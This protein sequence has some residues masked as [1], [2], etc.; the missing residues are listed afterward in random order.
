MFWTPPYSIFHQRKFYVSYVQ[1]AG[2]PMLCHAVI[3]APD[4]AYANKNWI[5]LI[6]AQGFACSPCGTPPYTYEQLFEV[7][8]WMNDETILEFYGKV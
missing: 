6:A 4:L 8:A 3:E 5:S 2:M 1:D 7:P